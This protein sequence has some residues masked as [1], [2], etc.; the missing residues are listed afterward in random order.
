MPPDYADFKR[1]DKRGLPVYLFKVPTEA[2]K[3]IILG[4]NAENELFDKVLSLR[5]NP[6]TEHIRI[7]KSHVDERHFRLNFEEIS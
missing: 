4:C 2:I 3:T 1:I 5:V 7:K 6:A